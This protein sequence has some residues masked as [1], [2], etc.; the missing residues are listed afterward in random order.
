VSDNGGRPKYPNCLLCQQEKRV[1]AF[2]FK[3]DGGS[4][5]V[6]DFCTLQYGREAHKASETHNGLVVAKI[7]NLVEPTPEEQ[8]TNLI[9]AP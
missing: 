6:C 4:F 9:I 1:Y 7:V 3:I 2:V 8:P 5:G